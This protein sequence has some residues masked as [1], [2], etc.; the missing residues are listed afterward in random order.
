MS[1]LLRPLLVVLLGTG[2]IGSVV[3]EAQPRPPGLAAGKDG[4]A[5]EKP[6]GAKGAGRK[7]F[8]R[9]GGGEGEEGG[10]RVAGMGETFLKQGNF[11][12]AASAFREELKK[13]PDAVAAH[14]GLGKALARL[15]RCGEGLAELWPHVGTKPFGDEAAILASVCSGRLGLMDDAL[16]FARIAAEWDP[17]NPRALTQYALSLADAGDTYTSDKVIGQL[18]VLPGDKDA[19]LYAKAV[20]AL[21][22]GD[23]DEFDELTFFWSGDRGSQ[24]D[25]ARLE[26]QSWLDLGNP[27][28]V[29]ASIRQ[30]KRL[31]RGRFSTWLR[32]E[33][34]RRLGEPEEALELLN[35]R[36][37]KLAEGSD[38]DAVRSR[39]MVDLGDLAGAQALL[40]QY[41][42]DVDPEV[43]ASWWYLSRARG[44]RA[45]MKDF[46]ALY[47]AEQTSP[48]RTL[49]DLIPWVDWPAPR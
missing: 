11:R 22:R 13:N 5:A 21:R 14:V 23:I 15:G 31:Q 19:S 17:E 6:G 48:E 45:A 30:I 36:N 33:A 32:A 10:K 4:S 24:R 26:A 28:E 39:V 49:G 2:L 40:E 38:S 3:A 18:E 43:T 7:K 9:P 29:V 35:T 16:F 1:R 37:A 8:R 46:S 44:D 27:V 12:A 20:L 47:R 34:T 25:L 42:S 41:P